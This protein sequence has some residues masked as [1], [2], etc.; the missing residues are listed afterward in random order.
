[1]TLVI[2]PSGPFLN[3]GIGIGMRIGTGVGQWKHTIRLVGWLLVCGHL[4]NVFKILKFQNE[5]SSLMTL[6]VLNDT[7]CA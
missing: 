3:I 6:Q 4:Q 1:M 2:G 5:A 7:T